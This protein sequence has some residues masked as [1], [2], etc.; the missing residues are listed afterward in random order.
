MIPDS[1][2]TISDQA[3][4]GCNN[5]AF[6]EIGNGV[7]SIG[8]QAFACANL[9]PES[10]EGFVLVETP[11]PTRLKTRNE[12]ALNYDWSSDM[13]EVTYVIQK[14]TLNKAADLFGYLDTDTGELSIEGTGTSL[15]KKLYKVLTTTEERATLKSIVFNT[16]TIEN[17]G[18]EWCLNGY[19]DYETKQN[20]YYFPNLAG[21]L[22]LPSNLKTIGNYAFSRNPYF[23]GNLIIP[24]GVTTSY[25]KLC[26]SWKSRIYK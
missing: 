26:F 23:V 9:D 5:V 13:R 1:V 10:E 16:D 7:D 17:I 24:D 12:V 18:Y 3:F 14:Y 25:W 8:V 15:D 2:T 6:I 19:Y 20:L 21:E 4:L 22:I 11:V